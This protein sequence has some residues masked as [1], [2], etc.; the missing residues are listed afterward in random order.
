M[1]ED[2]TQGHADEPEEGAGGLATGWH[3]DP[4]GRFAFRWW[5]GGAWTSSVTN[6]GAT[7]TSL[8]PGPVE[9]A[10]PPSPGLRGGTRTALAGYV[11][12]V[13]LSV[14]VDRATSGRTAAAEL[15][16]SSM[17]L[18][19]GLL[20]AVAVISWRRGTRSVVQDVGLRFRWSDLGFG[21]AGAIAGRVAAGIAI[22]PLP[23]LDPDF[24]E[25]NDR[26]VLEPATVDGRSWL[27]LV[28]VVCVG[29][30]LVEE[31][32]FR[33]LLQNRLVDRLGLVGGIGLTSLLFGAAHLIGWQGPITFVYAW[34]VAAGGVVL[35]AVYHYARRLGAA[36]VAHALFNAVAVIALWAT[37]S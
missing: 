13:G 27:I 15:A 31:I 33:G 26:S 7:G 6:G 35:G 29:A 34:A 25:G 1:A 23:L 37:T 36:I 32:F 5:D 28:L 8:D 10:E 24:G 20:G 19:V 17:A 4:F 2:L 3:P 22:L 16:M 9:T 30:P 18:W 14:L 21:L 11:A 12:G